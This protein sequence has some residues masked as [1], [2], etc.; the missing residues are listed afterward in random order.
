MLRDSK[1]VT[2]AP[3]PGGALRWAAVGVLVLG[4]A[5]IAGLRG[6][7]ATSPFDNEA[8]AQAP[9]GSADNAAGGI[10]LTHVVNDAKMLLAIRPAQVLANESIRK[11]LTEA[12]EDGP[13]ILKLLTLDNLDQVTLVG[14]PGVEPDDW[15]S[16]AIL[17]LQFSKAVAVDDIVKTGAIARDVKKLPAPAGA[18]SRFMAVDQPNDKTILLGQDDVLAKYVASR[19]KGKPEIAAGDAWAKVSKGAI[20]AAIDMQTIRDEFAKSGPP[21]GE[22]PPELGAVA[23]LWTDSEFVAAGVIVEGKTVHL[24]A[25]A[26]CNDAKLAENVAD[27]TKAAATLARNMMRTSRER[28]KDIP[29]FATMI[30]DTAEGLLKTVK[31]EQSETLVV[32]Q[33]STEIPDAKAPAAVGLLGAIGQARSSAQKAQSANNMRQIAI[34]MHSWHDLYKTLPPPV[35]YGK[36]GKGKVPHSWRVALLPFLDQTELYNAYQ[37]DEPWDSEANKKVLAKM[38]AVFRHP[39]D[40]Q[41]STSS[42]YYVLTPARLLDTKVLPGGGIESPVGGLPTAFSRKIGTGF[43][44]I[45]DGTSN[46]LMTVEA[47]REIPWTK[48]EDI[49]F[50]PEKDPP[51][52][53]GFFK[54][55][56]TVGMCDGATRFLSPK[57]EPKT[58]KLL[59]TPQDGQPLPAL[60]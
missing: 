50:D 32:A 12:R 41:D 21:R 15:N 42:A 11:A 36:D 9:A 37:F 16:D 5:L 60:P 19:R 29:A 27:T 24:R 46:T 18:P 23:P 56:F 8:S 2:K 39:T 35:I 53:G 25:V 6:G 13:P 17:I 14:P 55:G 10:D 31:I 58:L 28:E 48:P 52:L 59:I 54:D 30:F 22:V 26:T 33:T 38:P 40:K 49:L 20:V 7:P 57:F 4:A 47:K 44:E 1:P 43:A 34:A 3:R 45:I 51:A